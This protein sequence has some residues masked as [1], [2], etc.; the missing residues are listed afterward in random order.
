M[1]STEEKEKPLNSS[2][3]DT[4]SLRPKQEQR[5]SKTLQKRQKMENPKVPL[6]LHYGSRLP[7]KSLQK[8]LENWYR[9][10]VAVEPPQSIGMSIKEK[11][12]HVPYEDTRCKV[13][14]NTIKTHVTSS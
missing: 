6:K 2:Q 5:D 9:S 11:T 8:W 13:S 3:Y 7:L 10:R 12:I 4:S 14:N 1:G